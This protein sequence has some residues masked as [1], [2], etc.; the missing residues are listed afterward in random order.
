MAY[1]LLVLKVERVSEG[2]S[3]LE[4]GKDEVDV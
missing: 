2:L 1:L 3:F 4:V